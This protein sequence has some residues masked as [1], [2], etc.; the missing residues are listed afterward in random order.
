ML[1]VV[2]AGTPEFAR[3]A[4]QAICAAGHEVVL[5]LTQPDRPAGRGMQLQQSPVKQFALE[6]KIRVL[7]PASLKVNGKHSQEAIEA[8]QELSTI[9]FDLMVVAAYGLILP[10][11]IFD[12]TEKPGRYGCLNI[13]ASLLPRWRGA[14]PI[15][16]AIEA[17]DTQ[18]GICIMQMD[19]GLDTGDIVAEKA[20]AIQ[21]EDTA[22]RLHDRLSILGAEMIVSVMLDLDNKKELVRKKQPAEGV[23]YAN[24]IQKEEAA[25]DWQQSAKQIDCR[26]RAFNSF[27]GATFLWNGEKIKVWHSELTHS[28][29]HAV[30]G[31]I[32]A[33]NKEGV[34][35][36]AG[37]GSLRITEMQKPGGKKMPA[38]QVC[39]SLGIAV[40]SCLR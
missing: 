17:G 21:Y 5:V 16:R 11:E 2:F 32:L 38:N 9:D 10:Q 33:L 7:Q 20:I 14:A 19:L 29:E 3:Q 26:I 37:V 4:L 18:T 1:K 23:V 22:D 28:S 34:I 36:S 15:Q 12:I 8:I 39:Q 27:P 31:E 30:A 6:K 35:V 40:G 25:I 13:H 24:K